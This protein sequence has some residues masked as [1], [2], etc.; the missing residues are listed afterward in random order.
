MVK[1][2]TIKDS[3][4]RLVTEIILIYCLHQMNKYMSSGKALLGVL[5]GLAAGA[6]LGV[7][8]APGKGTSTRKNTSK[9]GEDLADALNDKIDEKFEDLLG[10]LTGKVKKASKNDRAEAGKSEMNV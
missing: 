3:G 9:K 5:A 7:L 1:V 4:H 8:F 10:A 2:L 6:A